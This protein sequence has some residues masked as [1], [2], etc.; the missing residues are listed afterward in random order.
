[1]FNIYILTNIYI[2]FHKIFTLCKIV[3]LLDNNKIL[4]LN[5]KL[6]INKTYYD[7]SR[8]LFTIIYI[9][10]K[11]FVN[12]TLSLC[13]V[14]LVMY[15]YKAY[16]FFIFFIHLIIIFYLKKYIFIMKLYLNN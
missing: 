11:E 15:M 6:N 8:K 16:L 14:S 4:H 3:L 10:G 1:M 5:N 2:I 13:H 9:I 7:L 12:L